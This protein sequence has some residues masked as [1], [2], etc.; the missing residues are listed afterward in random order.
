MLPELLKQFDKYIGLEG[1]FALK[2]RDSKKAKESV[3]EKSK[4]RRCS[5]PNYYDDLH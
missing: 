3:D 2:N 1:D 5:P 4:E